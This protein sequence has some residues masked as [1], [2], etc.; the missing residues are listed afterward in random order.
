MI[1]FGKKSSDLSLSGSSARPGCPSSSISCCSDLQAVE[2][3]VFIDRRLDWDWELEKNLNPRLDLSGI[4]NQS[5]EKG[6]RQK[7][8]KGEKVT[9]VR[10]QEREGELERVKVIKVGKKKRVRGS[11]GD[12]SGKKERE[13]ELEG[14]IKEEKEDKLSL[15]R[16]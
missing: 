5:R 15:T 7:K 12:K 14:A 11:E 9:R 16:S 6:E 10:V 2:R 3:A 13:G 8:S 4:L 1:I